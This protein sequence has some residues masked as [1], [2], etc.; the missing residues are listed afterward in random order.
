MLTC[1][2]VFVCM[3]Y[4]HTCYTRGTDTRK[5]AIHAQT[6]YTCTNMLYMHKHAIHAH[7]RCS[8]YKSDVE[9]L[10]LENIRGRSTL[11]LDFV[12]TVPVNLHQLTLRALGQLRWGLVGFRGERILDSDHTANMEFGIMFSLSLYARVRVRVL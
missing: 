3:L 9:G 5:H 2:Y 12:I 8:E 1:V 10:T 4:M 6:C 11:P 7:L